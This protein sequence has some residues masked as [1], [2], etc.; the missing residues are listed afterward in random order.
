MK[1][2]RH[3]NS[4][5][6]RARVILYHDLDF[7]RNSVIDLLA[8]A[9]VDDR[10]RLIA[11]DLCEEIIKDVANLRDELDLIEHFAKTHIQAAP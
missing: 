4:P 11:Q 3:I 2:A 6:I 7:K 10:C 1:S 8:L 9:A 5:L